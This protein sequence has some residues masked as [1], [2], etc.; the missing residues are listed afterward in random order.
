MKHF[1]SLIFFFFCL[2]GIAQNSIKFQV[3]NE[4]GEGLVGATINIEGTT[5]GGATDVEGGFHF[6]DIPNGSVKFLISFVGYEPETKTLNFPESNGQFIT[7]TLEE[8]EELEEVIISATRSSRTIETIPTR[9]EAITLEELGE[10]AVMNSSNISMVL[11]ESPGIMMQ[12]TSLSSGNMSIRIQGLD[13]RYTQM[14]RDG[15]PIY[16]GFAGGL[17][18]LQIPPLDLK[19]FEIIKGGNSTL[20]GGGA[21]AGIVNLVSKTP[22]E[23]PELT[24]M[25]DQTSA[26]GTTGNIFYAQKYGKLGL[27]VYGSGNNQFAYDPDND[28]FSNLPKAQTFTFN[29]RLFYYPNKNTEVSLGVG[30]TIDDRTG[31]DMKVVEGNPEIENVFTEVNKSERYNSQFLFKNQKGKREIVIKNN[32]SIFDRE[33]T[34]PNYLFNGQS[35]SSF[36]EGFVKIDKSDKNEWHLGLNHYYESFTDNNPDSLGAHDY[37]F[38]TIGA[39]VQNTR[40]LGEKFV[41]EGGLRTDYNIEHG[42]FVLPRLALLYKHSDKFSSRISGAMGYKL[43]T[44]F[45]ED[46]ERIYYRNIAP[47]TTSSL[48]P[49][50]SIGGNLDFNYK[51][52]VLDKFTFAI[53]QLF[54]FTQLNQALV[55]REDL[56]S[57]TFFYEN[58]GGPIQ[59]TGFETSVRTTYKDF[60]LFMY[61]TYTNTQLKYDNINEQQPLTPQSMAGFVFIYEL[62]DNWS[63]GYELYY[64]GQQFDNSFDKKSDYWTMG[65]MVMK[66]F[67][68]ITLFANFENFTNT[69]QTNYEPLVNDPVSNP[70]FNDIWAP[71]AGFVFNG[72]VKINVF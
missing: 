61:Y 47:I 66:H 52:I 9:I 15:A 41:F 65:F 59:S 24:I 54:F 70:T 11:R 20:Y 17:S 45:T 27:T 48:N 6:K 58:A 29:P 25:L 53:N 32:V 16:G 62:E 35:L 38:N 14:L 40:N 60:K 22:E 31:G 46:A 18:I 37:T 39:F 49:E 68:H 51:T 1:L 42:P 7:I 33:L 19:Q 56:P 2:S 36:S 4:E 55:L 57:S 12:Q 5:L 30:T 28:G 13:G 50:T 8:G 10:K 23:K 34:I 43:P 64:T 3:S 21:I 26:L 71:T 44:L 72:G 67:E 63:A 69:I